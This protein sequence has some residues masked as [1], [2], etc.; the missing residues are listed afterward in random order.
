MTLRHATTMGMID[1]QAVQY[2]D[3]QRH[4]WRRQSMIFLQWAAFGYSPI[5]ARL[6]INCICGG[7]A[8]GPWAFPREI[9]ALLVLGKRDSSITC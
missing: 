7:A 1:L 4:T 3:T 8:F 9:P 2:I 5:K 6:Y